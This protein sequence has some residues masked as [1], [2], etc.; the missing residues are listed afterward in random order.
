MKKLISILLMLTLLCSCLAFTAQ[1]EEDRFGKYDEPITISFMN[2][3]TKTSTTEYREGDP[4]RE[5]PYKN[6]WIDAYKDYLNIVIEREVAEDATAKNARLNTGMAD[7]SLPDIM[8]VSKDMFYVLAENEVLAD[9]SDALENYKEKNLLQNALDMWNGIL[10]TGMYEGKLLG[11]P[12]SEN[13]FNS[14]DVLWIR[15][16]WLDKVNME[17]PKT[18]DDLCAVGKAFMDAKLGGD[19]TYAIGLY[20]DKFAPIMAPFGS[21]F[22]SGN[23]TV[24][25]KNSDGKWIYAGVDEEHNVPALLK[26]QEMYKAGLLSQD[27][28]LNDSK[29]TEAAVANSQVGMVFG[30]GWMGATVIKNSYL[31]DETADWIA[32]PIPTLDGERVKQWTNGSIGTFFVVNENCEH[33]EALLKMIELELYLYYEGTP[34]E[35]LTYIYGADNYAYW[36]FRLFRNFTY[37]AQDFMRMEEIVEGLANGAEHVSSLSDVQYQRVKKG[38]DG[39]RNERGYWVVFTQA[40]PIIDQLNKDGLLVTSYAGPTTENMT[41][42]LSNIN[43]ALM[44]AMYKVVMGEDIS[45]YEQ[46]VKDWYKNGGQAITDEINAY[47]AA[48]GL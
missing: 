30:Q 27:F 14:T 6:I 12:Q 17:A 15:Q 35:Q 37:A 1:A 5:S 41:L 13:S 47:Y 48:N 22:G 45:V 18:I 28:A 36:D 23:G 4:T 25:V 10:D 9:L 21:L 43:E 24:C 40:Y 46:A 8:I 2:T 11:F 32:V 34:E 44:S 16:D 20:R 29:A 42:Y 26:M 19:N 38:A 39:D 31:N 33:P 7:G 3:D